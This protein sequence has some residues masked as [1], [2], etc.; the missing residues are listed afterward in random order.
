MR[1]RRGE[2]MDKEKK[3][4]ERGE[5]ERER[6]WGEKVRGREREVKGDRGGA[7]KGIAGSALCDSSL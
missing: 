5:R 1:G 7:V 4:R 6:Q 3:Q 2:G